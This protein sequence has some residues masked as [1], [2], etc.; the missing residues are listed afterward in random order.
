MV[1][2]APT[3][4]DRVPP[5]PL[6][7]AS[8]T[9][10]TFRNAFTA[11]PTG[12]MKE[13][14]LVCNAA[15][16][17]QAV[18]DSLRAS[19]AKTST[20]V[21]D[22]QTRLS[23]SLMES[24][25]KNDTIS[26]MAGQIE[27]YKAIAATGESHRQRSPEHP[28]P[29]PFNGDN[30]K[31]LPEFLQKLE[32]KLHMNRDWWTDETERMGFV[33]SCLSGDAHAQVSYNVSHGI[34]KFTNVEAIITTLKTV[35]GDIDP[36]ATAQKEIYDMKQGHKPLASFLPNWIA[37]AKL[38]EFE[39]KSL[40]SHLKRALHP[41]I[42]WRLVVLKATPTTL[43][44]FIELVRQ[45]DSEC[46]Q[47]NGDYYKKKPSNNNAPTSTVSAASG[48]QTPTTTNGGDAM[49][50][51]AVSWGAK[52]VASGRKPRTLEEKEARRAYCTAHGLCNWCNSPDHKPHVCPTAPWNNKEKK[53]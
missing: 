32:L 6:L 24:N 18:I 19:A 31:E 35:Y 15:Y 26:H 3:P 12:L 4:I 50:L 41:D 40:I 48:S 30:P 21:E 5:C 27:A 37:V 33:I 46:R 22:L 47:L 49:D 9:E 51:S 20:E 52:D 34:V 39:D 29:D 28:K 23:N 43:A 25:D 2:A 11:N 42:I 45:C 16:S 1:N 7:S 36:A 14:F 53:A 8:N 10:E 38:T 17:M 44:E 13:V